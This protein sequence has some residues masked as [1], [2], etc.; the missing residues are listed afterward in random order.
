MVLPLSETVGHQHVEHVGVGESHALV[1][2]HLAGLQLIQHH[3]AFLSLHRSSFKSERHRTRLGVLQV[4]V[5][6]QVIRRVEAHEAVDAD[7]GIVGRHLG[8]VTD[9][10]SIDHQLHLRILHPHVPVGRLY[11][12]NHCLFCSTHC[13]YVCQHECGH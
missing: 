2:A 10:L 13:Q 8:H 11:P 4:H 9:A 5:D 7:A 6:K 1:A 12:V 3:L